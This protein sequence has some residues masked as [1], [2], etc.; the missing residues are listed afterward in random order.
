MALA[1]S[2]ISLIDYS[3][4]V[5]SLVSFLDGYLTQ[6]STGTEHDSTLNTDVTYYE[7]SI[8]SI[9]ADQLTADSC[10]STVRL[11]DWGSTYKTLG[12]GT[13]VNNYCVKLNLQNY[14]SVIIAIVKGKC[15]FYIAGLDTNNK[16]KEALLC[17]QLTST[18]Y[19]SVKSGQLIDSTHITL[20]K[21]SINIFKFTD[22][23]YPNFKP[24]VVDLNGTQTR[25]GIS[26][27]SFGSDNITVTS[28]T[29]LTA[30]SYP[31]TIKFGSFIKSLFVGYLGEFIF[32]NVTIDNSS[33]SSSLTDQQISFT[34]DAKSLIDAGKLRSD[35]K[36]LRVL[37]SDLTELPFWVEPSTIYS[38][39]TK[40]WVKV[41]NIPANS[42]KTIYLCYGANRSYS[43]YQPGSVFIAVI[44]DVLTHISFDQVFGFVA[45]DTSGN[46]HDA[47]LSNVIIDNGRFGKG[48][49]F[50]GS[51]TTVKFGASNDYNLNQLSIEFWFKTPA[52][53]GSASRHIVSKSQY[54]QAGYCDF[55]VWFQS[56]DSN[57]ITGYRQLSDI[58]GS[59]ILTLPQAHTAD[60][61]YHFILTIS[62]SGLQK[63]YSNGQSLG[64]YQGT[65]GN[66]NRDYLLTMGLA[67]SCWNGGI[68]D[69]RL[70]SRA[71]TDDEV[72][73]L[74][75][76]VGITMPTFPGNVLVVKETSQNPVISVSSTEKA[77]Q[78]FL[79]IDSTYHQLRTIGFGNNRA[80]AD[81]GYLLVNG[82]ESDY[83]SGK[84]AVTPIV[85]SASDFEQYGYSTLA[86]PIV[87]GVSG[88]KSLFYVVDP[89]IPSGTIQSVNG[90]TVTVNI[91]LSN[92]D[93]QNKVF[94][95]NDSQHGYIIQSNTSN[96]ITVA[97]DFVTT[98]QANSTFSICRTVYIDGVNYI[99]PVEVS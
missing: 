81:S 6:T 35:L 30:S 53:M 97:T 56:S 88:G 36:N 37:D 42:T 67:D 68:D 82:F 26:G 24:Y 31:Q 52:S 41:P 3:T 27:V 70:Y 48:A 49:F 32:R 2:I 71:L 54:G 65:A 4:V 23:D 64:S 95:H 55:G 45:R 76:N 18:I 40:I 14:P 44:P 10:K 90:R 47:A 74:A 7:F 51:S 89:I 13:D 60:T 83:L 8:Q 33:N 34:F 66:A 93:L 87:A 16:P 19:P 20:P 69:F 25:I 84:T 21:G 86:V 17:S 99:V 85:S 91:D 78:A 58:F 80:I 73:A 46:N 22:Q 39:N 98:P 15:G 9:I 63:F 50:N 94:Y 11:Y 38:S 61:W 1:Y 43:D 62:S 72:Y 5:S 96:T 29:S 59:Y 75:N 28:D 92:I 77:P 79:K 12:L 57:T